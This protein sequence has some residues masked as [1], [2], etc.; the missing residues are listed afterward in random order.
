M[1]TI[2]NLLIAYFL[3]SIGS[4]SGQ[5]Q[6]RMV[7]FTGG[8]RSIVSNNDLSVNDSLP[9]TT[10]VRRSTGGYALID[11]GVDIQPNKSTEILGMFRIRNQYGGFWGAGV[12]FDVRQLWLKGVVGDIVRYQVGDLNLKQTPFTLYNHHADRFDSLPSVFAL[13][14]DIV[15]YERFYSGNTW[16]QQGAN[17][18]FGL[19]FA[20][21]IRELDF[22][23]Y[24]TRMN[25]T[26]FSTIPDRLLAGI[27]AVVVQ[28]KGLDLGYHKATMFNVKGTAAVESEFTNDVNSLT[29]HYKSGNSGWRLDMN[30]EAGQSRYENTAFAD[31]PALT[32][33]FLSANMKVEWTKMHLRFDGGYLN[34]GP[35]YRSVGAQS[36]DIDYSLLPEYYNRYTNSQVLRP[37]GITDFLQNENLYLS[38]VTTK[39]LPVNPMVN[40]I[41]PY[42]DATFNRLGG[43]AGVAYFH[44]KGWTVS[45]KQHRLREIRGQGTLALKEFV[46]SQ[47][48]LQVDLDKM[49]G[50]KRSICIHAGADLQ[51]TGRAGKLPVE[52]ITLNTSRYQAGMEFEVV[53]RLDVLAGY[54]QLDA[55]GNEFIPDRNGFTQIEYFQNTSYDL[56]EHTSA[57]GLRFRF[58]NKIY[59]CALYQQSNYNDRTRVLPAYTIDRFSLIYN[60]TF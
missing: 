41:A 4:A 58:D 6:K 5:Q 36:K 11:L 48:N 21:G 29:V 24:V 22:T 59:L 20:K 38:S 15:N 8:A 30:G 34:V 16:R 57:Y 55:K 39:L 13:Q 27:S 52:N 9:D 42:G 18:D 44:P 3:L 46:R 1:R 56:K 33:Y 49:F 51:T 37:T 17:V 35:D 53:K 7:D 10:T 25:A 43:Y 19:Q 47:V 45:V 40:N 14:S 31:Q 50:L 60:M 54:M 28:R 23:G 12:T 32:D 26:D 2:R